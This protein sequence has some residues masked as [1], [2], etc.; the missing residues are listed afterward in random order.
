MRCFVCFSLL[1]LA[2]ARN[3]LYS[4]SIDDVFF[5]V[6]WRV[7][8]CPAQIILRWILRT[9]S[10]ASSILAPAFSTRP[11]Y[12]ICLPSGNVK[13]IAASTPAARSSLF[14]HK[15]ANKKSPRLT[16]VQLARRGVVLPR[17]RKGARRPGMTYSV[18]LGRVLHFL[19]GNHLDQLSLVLAGSI[20]AHFG[21]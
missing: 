10:S 3:A 9:L 11:F 19:S 7:F 21:G 6:Y 13:A 2:V 14:Y 12:F 15:C 1:F 5:R 8:Q 20:Q 18:L 17:G 4:I 16:R